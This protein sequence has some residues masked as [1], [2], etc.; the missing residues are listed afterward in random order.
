MSYNLR[1]HND[2]AAVTT[3]SV[4]RFCGQYIWSTKVINV[5]QIFSGR[6]K[7]YNQRD[8]FCGHI[9]F[10]SESSYFATNSIFVVEF[11]LIGK[12]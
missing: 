3:L 5:R 11:H 2:L 10:V 8:C 4:M 12:Q 1:Q 9:N 7:D 6:K